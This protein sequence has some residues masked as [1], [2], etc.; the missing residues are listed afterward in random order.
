MKEKYKRYIRTKESVYE[1]CEKQRHIKDGYI[2]VKA[3][4]NPFIIKGYRI[5]DK[6]RVIKQADTIEDLCDEFVIKA[7]CSNDP[8]LFMKEQI[9]IKDFIS[10]C[11]KD[12]IIYGAIWC[13]W[14][15]KYVARMNEKGEFE[16]L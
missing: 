6:G 2:D 16:L 5:I 13:E 4:N 9:D 10:K 15:L 1:P 12:T 11:D 3:D 7:Y 14:G 8:F